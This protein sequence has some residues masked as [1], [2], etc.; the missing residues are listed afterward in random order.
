MTRMARTTLARATLAAGAL[1]AGSTLPAVASEAP[2][3]SLQNSHTVVLIAFIIFVGI[4]VYLKV[5]QKIGEML[6]KRAEAIRAELDQARRIREEAQALLASFERKLKEAQDQAQRIIAH[7]KEE[8]ELVAQEAKKE[9]EES[10][11]RRMKAAEE[12]IKSAEDKVKREVREMAVGI[13]TDA[14]AE[15]IR[16]KMTAKD[17]NALIDRTIND[18]EEKLH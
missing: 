11:R 14:A 6:D 5:P 13:A 9:L 2:F 10:V 1:V 3:F 16:E 17:A 12:Q 15:V 18:V 4:L 8:A 7:A